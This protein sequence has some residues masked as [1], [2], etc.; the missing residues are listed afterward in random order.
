M[1]ESQNSVSQRLRCTPA[2]SLSSSAP[3][4]QQARKL[5][6]P[7]A[8]PHPWRAAQPRP[9]TWPAWTRRTGCA[10]SS[11]RGSPGLAAAA[12]STP[13]RWTPRT[14]ARVRA[15]WFNY[16]IQAPVRVKYTVKINTQMPLISLF[17]KL[18]CVHLCISFPGPATVLAWN[19]HWPKYTVILQF[20][21][22]SCHILN[23][24][25]SHLQLLSLFSLRA[26][27]KSPF[28]YKSSICTEVILFLHTARIPGSCFRFCGWN[29]LFLNNLISDIS[30]DR[31]PT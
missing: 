20:F 31:T 7:P 15:I 16:D 2:G 25:N 28:F 6:G 13:S 9:G 14:A 18:S 12:R 19:Q 1:Q 23:S 21:Q 5:A 3:E 29:I 30:M 22:K 8:P 4:K 17:I 24:K 10:A 27:H 26:L 11:P